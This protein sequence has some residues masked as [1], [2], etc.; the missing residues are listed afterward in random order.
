MLVQPGAVLILCVR[1]CHVAAGVCLCVCVDMRECLCD[2]VCVSMMSVFSQDAGPATLLGDCTA[3]NR[4]VWAAIRDDV[5][6]ADPTN[7]ASLKLVD[8]GIIIC[9]SL[10]APRMIVCPS[11]PLS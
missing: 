3:Q 9:I 6:A 4:D 1:I 11:S 7:A 10:S 2:Y 8:S 5:I